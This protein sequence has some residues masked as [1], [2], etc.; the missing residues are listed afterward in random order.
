M[1]KFAETELEQNYDLKKLYSYLDVDRDHLVTFA[2]FEQAIKE[3]MKKFS[4]HKSK[5]DKRRLVVLFKFFDSNLSGSINYG[6]F[7]RQFF[8]RLKFLKNWR[9]RKDIKRKEYQNIVHKNKIRN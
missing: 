7:V 2:D 6:E 4:P 9:N 1:E 3:L 8:K 5:L